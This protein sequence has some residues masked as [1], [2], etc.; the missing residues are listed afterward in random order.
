VWFVKKF[1]RRERIMSSMS[2]LYLVSFLVLCLYSIFPALI[3]GANVVKWFRELL[4]FL[5]YLM[6]FP[7][8]DS[9]RDRQGLYWVGAAFL[10][11]VFFAAINSFLRYFTAA[12]S[13]FYAWQLLSGRQSANEALFVS[14]A[15]IGI[16][17]FLYVRSLALKTA[18]LS[19]ISFF[20][21]AL[22]FTFSRGYWIGLFVGIATLFLT[23]QGKPRRELLLASLFLSLGGL[24]ILFIGFRDLG[25]SILQTVGRRLLGLGGGTILLDLSLQSRIAETQV[26]MEKI[27]QNPILGWGLGSFI[28]FHDP[29]IGS[30]RETWYI[31]NGYLFLWLK[32]GIAGVACYLIF[33][34][35]RLRTAM[36]LF[37]LRKDKLEGYL[38]AGIVSILVSMLFISVSS[39]QFI[40]RESVFII[41]VCWGIIDALH[42]T[43]YKF[44]G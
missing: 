15:L 38:L 18:L 17:L 21:L 11:I 26:V 20:L 36:G 33:H 32:L 37:K 31:H 29:L 34:Y 44:S 6:Y 43:S 41:A 10:M 16:P 12:S 4:I 1:A 19:L 2:E 35:H 22:V 30:I 14:G 8:K 40:T 25:V 13:A 7:L 39:P 24:A 28:R 42:E 9:L 5:A 3:N 27:L 23:L